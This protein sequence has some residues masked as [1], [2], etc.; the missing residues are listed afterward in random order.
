MTCAE[1]AARIIERIDDIPLAITQ[2]QGS[3]TPL[4]VLRAINEGQDLAALLT[5]FLE[6]RATWTIPPATTYLNVRGYF[7]D[8]IAPLRL[9]VNG[10]RMRPNTL[11]ELDARED[12]WEDLMGENPTRYCA[13][14]FNLMAITPQFWGGPLDAQ[15]TYAAAPLQMVDDA[16][17]QLPEEFHQSLVDY[18][19]Y[20]I[21]LKEGAQGLSR[22]MVNFG[23]FMSEM[24]IL[25]DFVRAKS[26]AANYDTLPF[27]LAL[28]ERD[29]LASLRR[30][31]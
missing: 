23:R 7:A 8:Y 21:R 12:N 18:G 10:Q 20:R 28:Y 14:G 9:T 6:V 30:T 3:T 15:F 16:F 5:L 24:R 17:P 22:A 31:A 27:E 19:I 13:L 2:G 25:G 29:A 4:E 26:R 1:I 11:K